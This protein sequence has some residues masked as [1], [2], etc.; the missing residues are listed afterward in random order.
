MEVGRNAYNCIFLLRKLLRIIWE[1]RKAI[2]KHE[3]GQKFQARQEELDDSLM[4]EDMDI[5]AMID[6]SQSDI[7]SVSGAS[8]HHGKE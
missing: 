5:N 1:V 8:E 4:L 7:K 2:Q 3:L 6:D